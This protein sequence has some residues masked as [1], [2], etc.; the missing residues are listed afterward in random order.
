MTENE[1]REK[2][3]FRPAVF[4]LINVSITTKNIE[5]P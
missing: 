3:R 2:S 1:R 4:R 5:L